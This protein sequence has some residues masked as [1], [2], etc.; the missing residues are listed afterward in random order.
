MKVVALL[1]ESVLPPDRHWTEIL[2]QCASH[3]VLAGWNMPLLL[4]QEVTKVPTF[5]L[6]LFLK[7][8]N[9]LVDT[10]C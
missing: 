7:Y 3:D 8:E 10:R 5:S 1:L 2:P 4:K 6:A 9:R